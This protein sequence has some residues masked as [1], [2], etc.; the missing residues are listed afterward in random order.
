MNRTRPNSSQNNRRA[1]DRNILDGRSTEEIVHWKASR[2]KFAVRLNVRA[3]DQNE[4]VSVD[5]RIWLI[6]T[7]GRIEPLHTKKRSTTVNAFLFFSFLSSFKTKT[8][9]RIKF[10]SSSFCIIVF[11]FREIEVSRINDEFYQRKSNNF[12]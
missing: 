8:S 11:L 7:L 10:Q 5:D 3:C 12:F 9:V 6:L 1:F 2:L 4:H